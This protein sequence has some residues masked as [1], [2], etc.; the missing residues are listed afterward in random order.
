M[1]TYSEISD[2]W[3]YLL[4]PKGLTLESF[5]ADDGAADRLK[6]RTLF[7][8]MER[9]LPLTFENVLRIGRFEYSVGT[10][11]RIDDAL[12]ADRIASWIKQSDPDDPNNFFKL[13]LSELSVYFG[14]LLQRESRGEWHH[15][16]FPNF[17]QSTVVVNDVAFH[18]FDSLMKRCSSDRYQETLTSKW[19]TFQAVIAGAN[20][21]QMMVS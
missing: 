13:T 16:R 12:T 2:Q 19:K 11:R 1:P 15:A 9:E 7:E 8:Q 21:G 10:L 3:F 4:L 6:T 20:A 17:S 14:N 5:E 18:V